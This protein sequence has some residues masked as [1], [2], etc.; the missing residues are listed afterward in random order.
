MQMNWIVIRLLSSDCLFELSTGEL[1]FKQLVSSND[2]HGND[3]QHALGPPYLVIKL[4]NIYSPYD[5]PE[6]HNY[7]QKY[8]RTND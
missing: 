2:P 3:V 5:P 1:V 6:P 4:L 7:Q 8:T